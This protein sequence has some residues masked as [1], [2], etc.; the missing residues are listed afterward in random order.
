MHGLLNIDKPTGVSSRYVVSQIESAIRPLA[1]G[2]AGTLDPLATGVLVVCVGRGTK[3]VDYLHRFSK[4]YEA[5]FLLGRSSDTEDVTGII[6]P[7]TKPREPAREEIEQAVPQFLGEIQQQPPAFSALH[8]SGRRA[9]KLARKGHV[10]ELQPR[11]IVVQ[12]FEL[13]R[14]DY[15]E[16][17]VE[18]ECGSG[19]YVRSLGRDLARAVGTEAVMSQLR[20]T[21]VGPFEVACAISPEQVCSDNLA[22]LLQP[23]L[24]AVGNMQQVSLEANQVEQLRSC[25]VLF[26]LPLFA[27]DFPASA[28][29]AG[30]APDGRLQAVLTPSRGDRWKVKTMVG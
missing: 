18:I 9:Y 5:T 27:G 3:L 1:V 15:P 12:R 29:L 20:R 25:G 10:V 7:L 23:A 17:H 21:H 22:A 13:Q 2:H 28:E 26:D 4:T 16:L 6:Q 8:V 30:I 24:L 14:Y 11:T 19:T